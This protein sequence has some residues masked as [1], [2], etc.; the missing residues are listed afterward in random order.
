MEVSTP[1]TGFFHF[2]ETYK[3]RMLGR[4]LCQRPKR[5]FSISTHAQPKRRAKIC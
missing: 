2:Y 5:A 3:S 1:Y 4:Q